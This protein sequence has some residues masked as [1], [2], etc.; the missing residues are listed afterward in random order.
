MT[1]SRILTKSFD[2]VSAKLS[3]DYAL[4]PLELWTQKAP[5]SNQLRFFLTDL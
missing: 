1:K 4:A 3:E 2:K 5:L